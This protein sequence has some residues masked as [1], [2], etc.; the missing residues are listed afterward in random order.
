M[1]K[2]PIIEI[3]INDSAFKK[4][5]EAFKEYEKSLGDQPVQWKALE[6]A[7]HRAG[8]EFSDVGDHAGV[9]GERMSK[10]QKVMEGFGSATHQAGKGMRRLVDDS[11]HL[12]SNIFSI[13]KWLLKMGGLSLGVAGAGLFGIDRLANSAMMRQKS[14][15]GLGLTPGQLSAFQVHLGG[16]FLSSPDNVLEQSAAISNDYMRQISAQKIGLDPNRLMGE[17]TSK[18]SIDI[19]NQVRKNFRAGHTNILD[20]MVTGAMELG[21]SLQ[22]MRR[23]AATSGPTLRKQEGLA[24]SDSRS[25]GFSNKTASEWSNLAIQ[26]KKAGIQIESTLISKLAPLAPKLI[27]IS[28]AITQAFG[29]FLGSK[30]FSALMGDMESGMGKFAKFMNSQEFQSDLTKFTH[31]IKDVAIAIGWTA[32]KL[33]WI[34]DQDKPSNLKTGWDDIKWWFTSGHLFGNDL[35]KAK[36]AT[37]SETLKGL[38]GKNAPHTDPILNHLKNLQ[39][40]R[41]TPHVKLTVEQKAGA[42]VNVSANAL[43]R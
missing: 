5:H 34:T 9:L 22:D 25:L 11:K 19:I 13:G 36:P 4:F 15:R 26:F 21:F 27:A 3:E 17:N 1:A 40:P 37:I 6:E 39:K 12:A 2:K 16:R 8:S 24:V 14:G 31:G 32:T 33:G 10:S 29:N 43:G 38:A 30:G 23:L 41:A 42:N 28:K 35:V 7:I 20:P 18:R